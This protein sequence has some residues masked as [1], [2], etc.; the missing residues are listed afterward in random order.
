MNTQRF[1]L[2]VGAILSIIALFHTAADIW[3]A[4]ILLSDLIAAPFFFFIWGVIFFISKFIDNEKEILSIE[5]T[6][7]NE[8]NELKIVV[9]DL[10]IEKEDLTLENK[11]LRRQ[12][13]DYERQLEN[14][15]EITSSLEEEIFELRGKF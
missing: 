13:K 6:A 4:D 11:E 7:I 5:T 2:Y 12:I 1:L 8:K 10:F 3:R 14:Q 9:S 15:I